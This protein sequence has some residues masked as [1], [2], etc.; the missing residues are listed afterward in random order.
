MAQKV[1]IDGL[2]DAV[3]KELTEYADLA[4]V[5]MKA[6]DFPCLHTCL[7]CNFMIMPPTKKHSI[8][9]SSALYGEVKCCAV[10]YHA[11]ARAE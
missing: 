3:M 6:A 8:L 9:A 10:F 4:T 1:K 7:C 11:T 5:D 2:A